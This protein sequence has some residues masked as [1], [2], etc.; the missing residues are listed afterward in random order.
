[1]IDQKQ[2]NTISKVFGFIF[3]AFGI[4]ILCLGIP[5]LFVENRNEF[6]NIIMILAISSGILMLLGAY[7]TI[8]NA[9]KKD[10]A[11]EHYQ[12]QIFAELYKTD[13][14]KQTNVP[15]NIENNQTK[16]A[17]VYKPDLLYKWN[18]NDIEWKMMRRDERK[19]RI[20]EGIWVSL[21]VAFLGGFVFGKSGN[22][23]YWLGFLFSLGVG[24]LISFLKV[25]LSNNMFSPQGI[26][27]IVFT[28]NALLI[29]GKF[30]TI[31]DNQIH[32]DYLKPINEHNHQYLEFSIEWQTRKGGSNDQLRIYVPEKYHL[33]MQAILDYYCSKGV[34]IET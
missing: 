19:R 30:K 27:T 14:P 18:Y 4:G 16:D 26:N 31:Q 13:S 34:R 20:R 17:E 24:I 29:N 7:Q 5:F 28:T 23:S 25:V 2:S 33:E 32:L 3:I 21:L 8:K 11:L 6:E 9:N 22:I 10:K 12:N 15:S 1:M